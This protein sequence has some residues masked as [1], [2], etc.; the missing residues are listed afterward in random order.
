MQEG[1]CFFRKRNRR[2]LTKLRQAAA[3]RTAARPRRKPGPAAS[4]RGAR[5]EPTSPCQD[6]RIFLGGLRAHAK[7]SCL[8]CPLREGGFETVFSK[9]RDCNL[10]HPRTLEVGGACSSRAPR[11]IPSFYVAS[12]RRVVMLFVYLSCLSTSCFR[13]ERACFVCA[14]LM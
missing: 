14:R 9:E 3:R 6:Y 2:T 7:N 5:P 4:P 8:I 1:V 13:N 10:R 12:G 11:V